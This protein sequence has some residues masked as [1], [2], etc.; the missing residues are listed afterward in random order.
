MQCSKKLNIDI[1]QIVKSLSCITGVLCEL[2][3]G[4]RMADLSLA[5]MPPSASGLSAAPLM[6]ALSAAPASVDP[7][8]GL[9]DPAAAM[10]SAATQRG[11]S[12]VRVAAAPPGVA[13]F[14]GAGH[15]SVATM[16]QAAQLVTQSIAA[17][18]PQLY[19][20]YQ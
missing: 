11:F 15:G 13:A 20:Q 5:S 14:G 4:Y 8:A 2:H 12:A 19:T 1:A 10:A 17:A 18:A 7:Y 3:I 6:S 9:R 16:P